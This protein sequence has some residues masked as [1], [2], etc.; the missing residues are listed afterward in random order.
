LWWLVLSNWGLLSL[1]RR[2]VV[3]RVMHL[4]QLLGQGLGGRRLWLLHWWLLYRWLSLK[5]LL[6]LLL[7]L[8]L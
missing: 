2:L 3:L 4:W 7:L 6:L 8:Q 5:S 1:W